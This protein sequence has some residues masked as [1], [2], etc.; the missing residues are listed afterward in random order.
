M[1]SVNRLSKSY[2]LNQIFTDV[3]FS[4]LAGEKIGLVGPN[5]CGKTTLLRIING[6]EKQDSGTFQF[7]PENIKRAYLPQGF[8]PDDNETIIQ[9]LYR[10]V[11]I[12]A[13]LENDLAQLTEA[14]VHHPK[15][16]GLI[17]DY[18]QTLKMVS[19]AALLESEIPKILSGLGLDYLGVDFPV[20]KLSGGQKT[21]LVL[22]GTLLLD[23]DLLM[24]D[25]PTN[26]LDIH[27]L[28]WLED[29]LKL[30]RGGLLVI[31][32]DRVF[33]DRVCSSI[34]E[35]DP[36]TRSTRMYTGNYSR[37]LDEK[38]R[39]YENQWTAY[40]DQQEEIMQLKAAA[41]HLRGIAKFRVGG[42]ADTG[43]KFARGFF[44]NRGKGTIGRAT[45]IEDRI[46]KILTEEKIEKP[47]NQWQMKLEFTGINPTGRDV[48]ILENASIGFPSRL[49]IQPTNA[50]L[51]YGSRCCLLGSNGSGKTSLIRTILGE[52]APLSG[53]IR[54]GSQ[55]K[56]GYM[57]QD[58]KNIREESSALTFLQSIAPMNE[59][60]ARTFL[61]KF[62]FTGDDVF[63]P[64]SQLSYGERARL[65]LAG[66]SASGSNFLILDEPLNHLDIP[67]RN[68]FEQALAGFEGTILA[69]VHDRY[70]IQHFATEIWEIVDDRIRILR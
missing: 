35:M 13:G 57:E 58:Q 25:E 3:S 2:N 7:H 53:N 24:L 16:E 32:H 10:Y 52:I 18:D 44:A 62:L 56:P 23:P 70:F 49:L 27:M 41:A 46:E 4:V 43:D 33:L 50:V 29:W 28:Q 55:V 22:A 54:F 30:F 39:E 60:A 21:R 5:G 6:E 59:T 38:A 66:L 64:V 8:Q 65:M 14:M 61:H 9:F 51:R 11:E 67:S 34:L 31:S 47:G 63:I 37:Y 69:V 48:L 68:R 40:Q 19:R 20:K 17:N 36:V 1:L 26:H 15:D 12:P 45:Q 42:K